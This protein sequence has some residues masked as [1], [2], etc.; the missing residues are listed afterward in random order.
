MVEAAAVS[1]SPELGASTI[2]WTHRETC[3]SHYS[4][5]ADGI[6]DPAQPS[7]LTPMI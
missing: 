1:S 6:L 7:G 2:A 5:G 4:Q 3:F